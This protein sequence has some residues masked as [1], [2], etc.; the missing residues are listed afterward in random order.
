VRPVD[1]LEG[2]AL[3]LIVSEG[4]SDPV[5][6][7]APSPSQLGTVVAIVGAALLVTGLGDALARTGHQS[8]ALPMF[9]AG[10]IAIF[11]PCAWRLTSGAAA[12]GER[13]AVS[14]VLGVGL[15]ASYYMRS[16]LIF[17]WFDEL[18][19]GATLNRLLDSR[20][21]LVHN[22]IL[23]VSPYYPGL[24]LVTVAVKWMTGLPVVLAQ[25]VVVLAQRVVIVLCVFLVVER[26]FGGSARAGGIGVLVYAANPS[27]YT[28]AS[29]DYGPFALV[30]A[31]ATV[32]F[33]LSSIDE[34]ARVSTT[35]GSGAS[36]SIVEPS[37]HRLLRTRRDFMLALASFAALVVT[38]HL[39]AWL[40]AGLLAVWALGLWIDGRRVAARLI[41][42]AA[43]ISL[44]LVSGWTAFVGSHLFSYLGPLLSGAVTGFSSA[45]EHHQ[46][47]RPL[48]HTSASQGGSSHWE[49]A[50]MLA[51]AVCFC[52]V[53]VPS[54]LGVIRKRTA[55]GGVLRFLPVVVAA[56]YPFAMLASLSS[57]SSQ[58]GERTTTFIF[59]GMAIVIGIWL[60]TRIS[61]RRSLLERAATLL[62]A[63]VCFLG[64]MIFGSGPDVTYVP[65]PYLVGANQR[66]FSAPSLA[67]A[68]WAS[69][70]LPAG[71]N[72][73]ADRQ[74]G[75]LLAD[76]GD[77]NF[78]TNIS[79]LTDPTP[80]FFSQHFDP[81]ELSLIRKDRIRYIV[82]DRRLASSL[83]LFNSYIEPGEAKPGTRLT[84]TELSKFDSVPGAKRVYDNGPIQVYD[85]SRLLGL[86]PFVRSSGSGDKVTGT[87]PVVLIA[88][89]A[90]AIIWLVRARRRRPR[91][92]ITNQAVVRW[93]VGLMVFGLVIAAATIP[94][95]LP[96]TAIGLGGL[97][98]VLVI[99]L[100]ATRTRPP[101]GAIPT[102]TGSR[103]PADTQPV[104]GRLQLGRA[105]GVGVLVVA[106]LWVR[107]DRRRRRSA[108]QHRP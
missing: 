71:S 47:S 16:P 32:H 61:M 99:S 102:S 88:A 48:F 67:L 68:Q 84:I 29:W 101:S 76:L 70:H 62:I 45:V 94:S 40:T 39:T 56:G 19:H 13:V 65:G 100:A 38:H 17:D 91:L 73:A 108:R 78:V 83:P 81:Y 49:I 46:S 90:V 44:V 34:R 96:P 54:V 87:D 26:V 82:V 31:V 24:E 52:L 11:V 51:A 2:S 3:P 86:S 9:F 89:I 20:T 60:A 98:A 79:G 21:L 66:S 53:L 36:T 15:L 69:T 75:A 77:L 105:A 28:F 14:L 33:L 50:V 10:L 97:A 55:N 35:V 5:V 107:R 25:L 30:F 23:P 63:T 64:S 92:R 27:F 74:N 85:V 80:L 59:F 7:G 42:L 37:R 106:I 8:P 58:V 4:M 103:Q 18:I 95:H 22:S 93:I 57:E 41:G 6:A 12:R 104:S 43:A 72:V 1:Q